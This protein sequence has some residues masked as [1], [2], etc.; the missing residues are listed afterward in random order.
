[1]DAKNTLKFLI[2]ACRSLTSVL[3]D[4]K[5]STQEFS[6]VTQA[7]QLTPKEI[8]VYIKLLKYALLSLDIYNNVKHQPSSKTTSTLTN[9]LQSQKDE[10]EV[11]ENLGF[12]FSYLSSSSLNQIFAQ[13]I[14][15]ILYQTIK[16]QNLTILTSYFLATPATSC[17]FSTI[18]LKKLLEKME[19]MG[20]LSIEKSNLYLKLFKLV[21][22][23]VSVFPAENEKMLKPHLHLLVNKSLEFALKSK[24]PYNY[25]LLMRALFRSIGGGNHDLLYQEFLPLL[26]ILLQSLN[27]LQT[28]LHKQH[29]KDLFVELCLTVPVRLSSLLPYLPMLMDPLVSALN[30]SPTLISQV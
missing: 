2:L 1:M 23:S 19:Y 22:G 27:E 7:K 13:T 17:I 20:D 21:F 24:E 14:D 16:N 8:K 6:F 3:I 29:L 4:T 30:G 18:L 11:I 9:N 10:K 25:F 15:L 26:P 5:P 12:I 28:G